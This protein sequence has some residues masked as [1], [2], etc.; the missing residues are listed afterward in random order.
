VILD[1]FATQ[2]SKR[3]DPRL[4]DL[5]AL[6]HA[7]DARERL[8]ALLALQSAFAV[9]AEHL[10]AAADLR[11]EAVHALLAGRPEVRPLPDAASPE[12]YTTAEKWKRLCAAVCSQLGAFHRDAPTQPGMEMA[13][14]RSQVA[15]DVPAKVFRVLVAE[16]ERE[17]VAVRDKST[18]RL[19]SHGTGLGT[20]EKRL[21]DELVALLVKERFTPPDVKQVGERLG[22]DARRLKDLLVRIEREGRIARVMPD[23]CFAAS[24][25]EEARELIRRHVAAHGEITAADFRD[26]TNASRKF[27]I[28]LLT[29]FYRTGFTL[30][31][32]DVRKLRR[33]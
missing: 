9:S 11:A 4:P 18:L 27:S 22:I 6:H 3:P 33:S 13:S 5:E 8:A 1:P 17:G 12:V 31:V 25:V 2:R 14:L 32:G 21:A 7:T 26:M 28:G 20:A 24:V 30:R 15:A 23:L 19:P 10:A 29:Y 16:L